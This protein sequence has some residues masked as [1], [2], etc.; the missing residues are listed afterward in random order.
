MERSEYPDWVSADGLSD[1]QKFNDI[2]PTFAAF[3]FGDKRLGPFQ[4]LCEVVLGQA[5]CLASLNH[6]LAKGQMARRMDGFADA[7]R[8]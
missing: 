5:C 2:D 7:A 6:Q 3:V 1:G 8:A 4:A